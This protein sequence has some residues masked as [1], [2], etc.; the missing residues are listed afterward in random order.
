MLPTIVARDLDN[1]PERL[2]ASCRELLMY[3][4][5]KSAYA[6]ASTGKGA[7]DRLQR[8]TDDWGPRLVERVTENEY[9]LVEEERADKEEDD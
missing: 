7:K 6:S 5:C 1:D 4:R 8:V 2:S 9:A 3:S